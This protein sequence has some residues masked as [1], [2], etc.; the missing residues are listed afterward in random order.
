MLKLLGWLGALMVAPLKYLGVMLL[1]TYLVLGSFLTETRRGKS[2]PLRTI[3][4]QVYF[5]GVEALPIII[6]AGLLLGTAVIAELAAILPVF[7]AGKYVERLAIIVLVREL[8][9]LITALIIIGR[10]GTAMAAEL[11]NMK[12]NR[13]IELLDSLGINIDYFMVL[14]RLVGGIIATV[15]LVVI[16]NAVALYGGFLL[17]GPF[18][19][20]SK[21]LIFAQFISVIYHE[22]VLMSLLK[23]LI[24]GWVIAMVNCIQ[25][26]SVRKSFTEVPQV[27]T[28]GVVNSIILCFIASIFISLYVFPSFNIN[29]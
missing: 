2:F 13:E 15:C 17:A 26:L 22:D 4:L 8:I 27:T 3:L 9:P 11:G 24:F 6:L 1:R 29:I 14:P 19:A 12:L 21:S 5:T 16:F 28:S 23:A 25:G 7:G 18:A 10:S 20:P